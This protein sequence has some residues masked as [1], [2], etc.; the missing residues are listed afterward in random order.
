MSD[1]SDTGVEGTPVPEEMDVDP[2]ALAHPQPF[3]KMM[4]EAAP[5]MAMEGGV[6]D[7]TIVFRHED[8][9]Q[10][11]HDPATFSSNDDAVAIGQVR[12]L[13]PLQIDPPDHK[14]Y[15]R[16]LDPLFAPKQVA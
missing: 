2:E 14:T 9:M 11:L 12:P 10:V 6:M 5:V 7:A 8:V 3:H 15:R 13:I 16:L 1:A 4:R